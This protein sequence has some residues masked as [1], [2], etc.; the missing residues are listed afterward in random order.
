MIVVR[1]LRRREDERERRLEWFIFVETLPNEFYKL[2]EDK[3]N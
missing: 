3:E 1:Q 2:R